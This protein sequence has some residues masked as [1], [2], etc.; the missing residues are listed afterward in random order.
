VTGYPTWEIEGKFYGGMQSLDELAKLS[1][2]DAR[3][4]K[5]ATTAGAAPAVFGD[6]NCSLSG[7]KENCD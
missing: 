1:G 2:F 3:A 6:E 7:G 4:P 5:V